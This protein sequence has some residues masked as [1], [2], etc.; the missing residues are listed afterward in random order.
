MSTLYLVATPIGNL[1]DITLR[2]L[3]MLGEVSLIAAEDTRTTRKLLRRY[4]IR[5]PLVSYYEA[6]RALRIPYLLE[7]LK[8]GDVALVS[9]AGTPG[10]RDP[11]RE[12][13]QAAIQEGVNVVPLPGP[14]A[15]PTALAAAGLPSDEF[16]FVGFLPRRRKERRQYLQRVA[17]EPYTTVAFEAPHR[18]RASLEDMVA[19]LGAD[20]PVVVCRELTKMYEEIYHGTLS[21]AMSHFQTPRGEFTLVIAGAE[22]VK[23]RADVLS[24]NLLDCLR[25]LRAAGLSARD[26]VSLVARQQRLPRRRVYEA[27]LDLEHTEPGP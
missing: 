3:R 14:S 16:L 9:E 4:N 20:R 24:Q 19:T 25:V 2:A 12:L 27:W 8:Q 10:I 11:G 7:R 15:I 18:L 26:A 21:E 17:G 22:P 23:K 6:N 5:T 1:E 13:V